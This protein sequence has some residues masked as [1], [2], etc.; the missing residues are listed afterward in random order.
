[1]IKIDF[2]CYE[3][4]VA[5]LL[6][7]DLIDQFP[8]MVV[9]SVLVMA[10]LLMITLLFLVLL[11]LIPALSPHIQ[12][13]VLTFGEPIMALAIMRD[14]R[15]V[16]GTGVVFGDTANNDAVSPRR[17]SVVDLPAALDGEF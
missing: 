5:K 10:M 2:A 11:R 13:V 3:P 9:V 15:A 16:H 4:E 14:D 6:K 8:V 7:I 12:R 1:M 17:G